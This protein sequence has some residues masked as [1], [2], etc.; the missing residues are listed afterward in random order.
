MNFLIPDQG[1]RN[2]SQ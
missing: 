1:L 2:H